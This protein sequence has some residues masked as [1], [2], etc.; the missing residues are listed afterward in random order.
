MRH[1]AT[2]VLAVVL[3]ALSR[4]AHAQEPVTAADAIQKIQRHYAPAPPSNTVDTIKAGDPSA[5]VTGIAT[6]S[7]RMVM[8]GKTLGTLVVGNETA[9]FER[10]IGVPSRSLCCRFCH[11]SLQSI[12]GWLASIHTVVRGT[13]DNRMLSR[14]MRLH[15]DQRIILPQT[16]G[17]PR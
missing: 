9:A 15:V 10:P 14:T 5:P 2:P 3:L 1:L 16:I 17:Y 4:L 13:I 8:P 6:T 12:V 11:L 7:S